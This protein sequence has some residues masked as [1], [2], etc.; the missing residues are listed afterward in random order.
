MIFH[1][2]KGKYGMNSEMGLTFKADLVSEGS[3]KIKGYKGQLLKDWWD[4]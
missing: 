2:V 3:A 1:W 4:L